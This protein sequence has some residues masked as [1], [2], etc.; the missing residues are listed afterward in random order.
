LKN[1]RLKQEGLELLRNW[2]EA[3]EEYLKEREN[4]L[5]YA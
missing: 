4:A 3:L 2:E 5:R 1:G